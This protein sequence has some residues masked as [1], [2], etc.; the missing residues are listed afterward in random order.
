M[1]GKI[2]VI[3]G[4]TASGKSAYG[5]ELAKELN[6]EIINADSMQVYTEIPIISAQPTEEERVG[7]PHHLYGIRS[8]F[9]GYSV[10]QFMVD[11]AQ[12]IIE[13][14]SL[15]KTPILVGGTGLYLKVLIEGLPDFPEISKETARKVNEISLHK[16][17]KLHEYLDSIDPLAAAQLKPNDRQRILRA[18][19]IKLEC[20][21]SIIEVQQRCKKPIFSRSEYHIMW[22]NPERKFLY[23]R[24]NQRF[25]KMVESG[26]VQEVA[27]LVNSAD[28]RAL[29]KAC[30]IPEIAQHLQGEISL[31][32]AIYKAQKSSRNYA[33]RQI[34]WARHQFEFDRII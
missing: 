8:C 21:H 6:G 22:I 3:F 4:A 9:D 13:V 28:G 27:D 18:I 7:I 19:S 5:V 26:A 25:L 11:A 20:G 23:E 24:I 2:N 1:L 31:D 17:G 15:A 30:G 33:K 34:T 10:G 16:R 12:K 29:P 14:Q 32:E